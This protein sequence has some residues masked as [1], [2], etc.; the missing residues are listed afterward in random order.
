MNDAAFT[1]HV[2]EQRADTLIMEAAERILALLGEAARELRPF[3][4]F[5][6]ALFSYGVEVEPDGVRNSTVGCVVVTPEGDLKELVMGMDIEALAP[7]GFADP[8]ALREELF[9]DLELPPR[10]RLIYAYNGLKVITQL[11]LAQAESGSD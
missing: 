2:R 8:L 1:P 6:G 5:P 9:E 3:P 11:L 7:A 4:P 10:D